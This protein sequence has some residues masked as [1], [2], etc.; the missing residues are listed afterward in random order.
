MRRRLMLHI[1]ELGREMRRGRS[2]PT[3]MDERHIACERWCCV[4][5]CYSTGYCSKG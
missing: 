1:V 2:Y 3:V 4:P 5:G